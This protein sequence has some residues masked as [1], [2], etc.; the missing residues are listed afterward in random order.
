MDALRVRPD[1]AHKVDFNAAKLSAQRPQPA[2]ALHKTVVKQPFANKVIWITGASSGIGAALAE[3]LAARGATLILS[4][5][6]TEL[7]QQLQSSLPN[8]QCHH[9]LP[10]DLEQPEGLRSK[11][12]EAI[13]L[14]GPVDILINNAGL[15]QRSLVVETQLSVDR[16][17]MEINF[18]GT[19]AMTKAMLPS[20]LARGQG[21]IMTVS[22]V[23]GK[24]GSQ[25]RS[26]YSASKHALNG[27]MESLRAEVWH[28]GVR[29][30][31]ACPGWVNTDIGK[32]ALDGNGNPLSDKVG[33]ID[34]GISAEACAKDIC[35]ALL[36]QREEI[37]IGRGMS[38]IAPALKRLFPNLVNRLMR[39]KVYR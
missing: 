24:I 5:R 21:Q 34:F 28:T 8:S 27:Y 17:I 12:Q 15:A 36:K 16:R 4:A 1:L 30:Q 37:V 3:Y 10:L 11:V 33:T 22:S 19:V 39:Q 9:L 2:H 14:W 35:R 20:M 32:A 38:R 6:R 26:S 31:L 29:V 18:F 23:A 25:T 7:L 13:A